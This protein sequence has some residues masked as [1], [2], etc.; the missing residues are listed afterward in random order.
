MAQL[1]NQ[2][3]NY[4]A[5]DPRAAQDALRAV[6]EELKRLQ[7]DLNVQLAQDISRLRTEKSLLIEDIES[8]RV[9][10]RQLQAQQ[11]ESLSQQQ[12]VQ[13]QRWIKQLAQVMA[14]HLQERLLERIDEINAASVQPFASIG[15][16]PSLPQISPGKNYNEDAYR[17]LNSLD[18]T[19]NTTFRTLE[20]ELSSY[21][22]AL[23]QQLGRMHSLEKQGEM[24]LETLVSRLI[25]QIQVEVNGSLNRLVVYPESSGGRVLDRETPASVPPS[26]PSPTPP[27]PTTATAPQTNAF[28][29]GL[30]LI[31]FSSIIISFQN[32]VTRVVLREKVILGLGKLGGFISPSAGNSLLILVMRLAMVAPVM[33]FIVA[34]RIYP[35]TWRDIRSL[36]KTENRI[37]LYSVIGSGFFLFLSQFFI[38]IAL[39][40]VATGVATTIFFVYPTITIL[41]AW[42]IFG[43]RPTFLLVLAAITIYIGGYLTIPTS[44]F[45]VQST[46][47]I[48][49]GAATAAASGVAFAVYVI[50]IKLAKMHP[51]PF[52]V[53]NFTTI[54]F[55]SGV[56][57]LSS[58]V[59]PGLRYNVD[60]TMW[61]P[62]SCGV[63]VMAMTTLV[64]YLLNNFGVP[65]IGPALAS[66]VGASGPALT[67]IM[68]LVLI[69]ESLVTY[70]VLGVILVTVWVLGISVENMKKAQAP[71]PAK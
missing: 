2:P 22:S 56:T 57:L 23:S 69:N 59:L 40:N 39:G 1:D 26:P 52:S 51:A 33:A 38:Y 49:L 24:I 34:P 30:L 20:Q 67:A 4:G 32:V 21:Q 31:L 54:L 12:M 66:V 17:L 68:A 29:R 63:A 71:K 19:L 62:L 64:G 47:N 14:S 48:G 44:G 43:D 37:K 70:Q 55:L 46:G 36:L 42:A 5:G 7:Q 18:A 9:Q 45:T 27:P 16:S 60:P 3:E 10:Y 35:H 50:L 41:L 53:V 15:A 61:I 28:N 13:Q 65:L 25:S 8:L 58:S 6:T 11:M